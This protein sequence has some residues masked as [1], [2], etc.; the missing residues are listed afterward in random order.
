ML[1]AGKSA[2]RGV[3]AVVAILSAACVQADIIVYGG[4]GYS[5]DDVKPTSSD[6]SMAFGFVGVDLGDSKLVVGMDVA[7]EG[8]KLD[9]TYGQVN[10]P[11]RAVSYNLLIGSNLTKFNE[12]NIDAALIAGFREESD[13]CPRSYLG[14]R[15]YAD[16]APDSTYVLNYGAAFFASYHN[17]MVGARITDAS[18]QALVGFRF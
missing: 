1:M 11:K 3:L 13:S 8:T 14:Y 15:C 10:S 9:S 4:S 2:L 6:P 5:T 17:L 7:K 18:T 16:Q 12:I